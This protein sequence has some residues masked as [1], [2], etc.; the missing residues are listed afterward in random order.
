MAKGQVVLLGWGQ[1]A[2]MELAAGAGLVARQGEVQF[3]RT[4]VI[5]LGMVAV[6]VVAAVVR[7]VIGAPAIHH[8]FIWV[9][10]V[11]PALSA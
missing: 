2:V 11:L 6:L 10:L 5:H 4:V 3:H 8:I 7:Q 1:V 9:V